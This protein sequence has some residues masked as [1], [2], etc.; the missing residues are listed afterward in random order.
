LSGSY[1]GK[2]HEHHLE[3]FFAE[4]TKVRVATGG[5]DTINKALASV[6]KLSASELPAIPGM[7]D[8]PET[9]RRLAALHRK[10]ARASIQKDKT[11]FWSYRDAAKASRDLSAQRA[12]DITAALQRLGVIKIVRVG[13]ARPHGRKAA[14]FR[15]LL[16]TAIQPF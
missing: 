3:S 11:Y 12:H 13:I 15:Y 16:P 4:L 5:G 10:L 14:E 6:F 9:W 8:A 1:A 2:T 7:P